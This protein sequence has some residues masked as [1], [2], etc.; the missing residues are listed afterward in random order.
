MYI[1]SF[2]FQSFCHRSSKWRLQLPTTDVVQSTCAVNNIGF[3]YRPIYG[4]YGCCVAQPLRFNIK[5][6]TDEYQLNFI[7][8]DLKKHAKT[9]NKDLFFLLLGKY[10]LRECFSLF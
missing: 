3:I 9:Y 6:S 4:I 8:G 5:T 1:M 10:L 2:F 7:V